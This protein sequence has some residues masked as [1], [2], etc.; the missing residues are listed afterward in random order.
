M[1]DQE[2]A[3]RRRLQ[4]MRQ[5]AIHADLFYT[6]SEKLGQD[7]A[8]ALTR[9]RRSQ[10]T[11]LETMANGALKVADVLDY[12]KA[13]TARSPA[14]KDWQ[15][16]PDH[17]QN[18]LGHQLIR[19]LTGDLKTNHRDPVCSALGVPG[20]GSEAQQIY[21]ELIRTFIHQMVIQYEYTLG[22]RGEVND[23]D[24]Q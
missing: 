3:R 18:G 8:A 15:Y 11:G 14:G 12:I 13:R 4:L 19:F 17:Q 5:I 7:A 20:D 10:M 6:D 2:Q 16:K 22:A 23:D 21:L 1:S 9:R 24:Q